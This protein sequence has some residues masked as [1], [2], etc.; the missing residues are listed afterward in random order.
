MGEFVV[1]DL[2]GVVIRGF[3]DH[4]AESHE[5][6]PLGVAVWQEGE[7]FV[8]LE[9]VHQGSDTVCEGPGCVLN[10]VGG[11]VAVVVAGTEDPGVRGAFCGREGGRGIVDCALGDQDLEGSDQD[12]GALEAVGDLES[13]FRA[14][15]DKLGVGG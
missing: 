11:E 14:H 8:R 2:Q 10:R 15:L 7:D 4:L 13:T 1:S 3:G 5:P 9:N 12:A 6:C